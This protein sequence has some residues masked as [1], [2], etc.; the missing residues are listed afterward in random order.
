MWRLLPPGP[1][2][3][4]T[5]TAPLAGSPTSRDF[6]PLLGVEFRRLFQLSGFS[7]KTR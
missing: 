5:F 7:M 4:P 6:E 1:T 3:N 2:H